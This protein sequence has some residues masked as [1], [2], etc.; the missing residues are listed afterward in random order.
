MTDGAD[1]A[2][3][4]RAPVRSGWLRAA[5]VQ[6]G[7]VAVTI[8]GLLVLTFAL[9]RLLPGDPVFSVLGDGADQTA[10]RAMY[11]E[12]GLDKPV[13]QQ[14]L[15]YLGNVLQGDFGRSIITK[16]LVIYDIGNVFAASAELALVGLI[17]AI[18]VGIPVGVI[19]AAYRNSFWDYLVRIIGL[20]GYSAP[21]FWI[22]LVALMVF[23]GTLGWL[24]G[25]GR[26]SVVY[27]YTF[28]PVT[29]FYL[30]DSVVQGRWDV[31][32]DTASRLI[33][34]A[35]VL[36]FSSAAYIARMTRSFMLEQLS[37]EYIITAAVKGAS[38]SNIIWVQAFRAILVQLITVIALVFAFMLEGSVLVETI[39]AWSG[40]GRY[41]VNAITFNDMNATIASVLFIGVIFIVVNLVTDL[42]YH[43]LD[44]RTRA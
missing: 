20:I 11:I 2:N 22:S 37:Q 26:I 41:M 1:I 34:P 32:R 8:F 6:L 7:S 10:Y 5:G 9:G 18:G 36:S 33:L 16:N 17:L 21:G 43:I 25:P 4:D 39:F 15:L 3:P 42:L 13:W 28:K 44:P 27:Q 14:F 29:G 23:Y 30:I 40:L 12:L 31:F 38:Y 19:A 24:P 35:S